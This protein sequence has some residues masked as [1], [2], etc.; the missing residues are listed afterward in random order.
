MPPID[1][2]RW[3]QPTSSDPRVATVGPLGFDQEGVTY[4]T[5]TARTPGTATVRAT[6]R[7]QD[8]HDLPRGGQPRQLW[9]LVITVIT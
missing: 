2:D 3:L 6:A 7:P 1:P 8:S 5:V 9:L 4:T